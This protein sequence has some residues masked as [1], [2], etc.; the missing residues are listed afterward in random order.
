GSCSVTVRY[1]P[2]SAG[3]TATLTASSHKHHAT[4]TIILTGSGALHFV[5]TGPAAPGLSPLNE[6]PAHPESTASGTANVT[7]DTTTNRMTVNVVF[8]GL[9]TPNTAAHIHCCVAAPG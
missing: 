2:T 3:D 6:N 8:A 4:A 5:A 7:W 9:T 1:A